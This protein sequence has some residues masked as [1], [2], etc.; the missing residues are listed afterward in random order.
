VILFIIK[1]E[2]GKVQNR[3][4]RLQRARKRIWEDIFAQRWFCGINC[5][6]SKYAYERSYREVSPWLTIA[7]RRPAAG[8]RMCGMPSPFTPVKLPTAAGIKIASKT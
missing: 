1:E 7:G 6:V 5:P 8:P 2:S 3:N 4:D